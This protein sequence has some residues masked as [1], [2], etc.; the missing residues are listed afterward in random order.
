MHISRV[1]K[2]DYNLFSS[3]SNSSSVR[4]KVNGRYITTTQSIN[5][6]T[7]RLHY[8]SKIRR[9][10]HLTHIDPILTNKQNITVV[11]ED[12]IISVVA[13]HCPTNMMTHGGDTCHGLASN[14]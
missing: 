7:H 4:S 13:A 6:Q 9:V 12:T 8:N 5:K 11:E 10:A 1:K 3:E 2:D 14:F